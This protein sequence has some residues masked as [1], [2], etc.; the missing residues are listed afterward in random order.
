MVP[1]M[2]ELAHG[3][4]QLLIDG[5]HVAKKR[6]WGAREITALCGPSMWVGIYRRMGQNVSGKRV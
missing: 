4:S 1:R 3:K 2:E 5:G 6:R